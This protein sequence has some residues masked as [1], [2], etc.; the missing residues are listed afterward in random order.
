MTQTRGAALVTGGGKRI[1]K[2]ISLKL[3][4]EGYSLALHASARS[5]AEAESVRAQI[6]AE[7]GRAC[8]LVAD[9]ATLDAADLVAQSQSEIGPLT[10]LVNNASV[11]ERDGAA[12][13]D[14]KLF[15]RHMAVNLRAPLLL[16]SAFHAALPTGSRGVIVNV[17]D[18]RVARLNPHYFSY[19]LSKSA[20]WTATKTLAQSFAPHIRVN[21]VAPGPVMPNANDGAQAFE[22]EAAATPLGA[23][24]LPEDIADAVAYLAN[25]RSVTGQTIFVDGGQRLAWRTPDV[26]AGYED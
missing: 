17:L 3:A 13:F 14:A 5:R 25:A 18:Q 7:G 12:G 26:I 19:T 9:L 2:A 4:R 16:A 23:A 11:F 24:A 22:G 10:A 6:E 20:L 1:G 21:A 8:V 15:D